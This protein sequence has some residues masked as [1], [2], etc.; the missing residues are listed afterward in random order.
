[1]NRLLTILFATASL[2]LLSQKETINWYFGKFAGLNFSTSPPTVLT[3]GSLTT[4]EG[5]ATTSDA[6]GNLLFYTDGV[7]VYDQTHSIMANGTGLGGHLSTTQSALIVRKP[8]SASLYYIFTL[9][10][11]NCD[12]LKY[13][14]VDMTLASGM[15]SVTTKN[16]FLD[17]C[18][19]EKC[20]GVSHCNGIDYWIVTH[21]GLTDEFYAYLL[22]ASGV[23]STPV[24]S[25]A[26]TIHN[27]GLGNMKISPT[28]KKLGLTHYVGNPT[29]VELFDF[30]N[31]TGIVSNGIT[32]ANGIQNPYGCEFSPDGTRFYATAFT[33]F[34]QWDLCAGSNSA[35]VASEYSVAAAN[36]FGMQAGYDGKVY[37]ARPTQTIGVINN[38]NVYGSGL[39][40]VNTGQSLGTGTCQL[41][42]PNFVSSLLRP[43][44]QPF[45][46]TV[47]CQTGSFTAT[48]NN[49]TV[50][51]GCSA[52]TKS[53]TGI[54]WDFG[55]PASG[56]SNVS[57][58]TTPSHIFTAPGAYTVT[59]VLQYD[60]G[61]DTIR[62]PLITG[63]AAPVL[64]V[65]GSF[66]VCAG[67]KRTYTVSGASTYKWWNGASTTTIVLTPTATLSYSVTGTNSA[68][69]QGVKHFTISVSKCLD[70]DR[71]DQLPEISIVPNPANDFINIYTAR[72]AHLEIL[73]G[74]G[75]IVIVAA[76]EGEKRLD[77]SQ[78]P[79]GI[80]TIRISIGRTVAY[81]RLVKRD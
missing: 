70:L 32:L 56:A 27:S 67:E 77:I 68:G 9:Y 59:Q 19:A 24:V 62:V 75:N 48:Q 28:G 69:C 12:S 2:S 7:T 23:S 34:L 40:Y 17:V 39:N 35:I 44:P 16:A 11:G 1:M 81:R 43:K 10:A 13:S 18:M 73:N 79:A 72:P 31:A 49:Y 29:L 50:S 25:S 21:K 26:G 61:T 71:S 14:I 54:L 80:Y 65:S 41:G 33:R 52:L 8:G 63:G 74:M 22:T 53:V 6:N 3:N 42:L 15:G 51:A 45:N 46:F 4:L 78:L 58:L 20:A 64:T 47:Q 30:D 5:C 38:P 55:D 66:S 60:C 76:C 36:V 57:G 37:V